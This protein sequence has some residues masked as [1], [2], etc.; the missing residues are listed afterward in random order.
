MCVLDL[1]GTSFACM[2]VS[3]LDDYGCCRGM[4]MDAWCN[5][6]SYVFLCLIA[7]LVPPAFQLLF[8]T[9]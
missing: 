6:V 8:L 5:Y 7:Q 1:S 2:Y 3:N 9:K 4:L